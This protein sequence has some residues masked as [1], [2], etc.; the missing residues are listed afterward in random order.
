MSI[1][2]AASSAADAARSTVEQMTLALE[3][4][5][6]RQEVENDKRQL[7]QQELVR[8]Q[9]NGLAEDQKGMKKDINRIL[10]ML[11]DTIKEDLLKLKT[12]V[13]EIEKD[14][15]VFKGSVA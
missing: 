9:I 14:L 13:V 15:K 8:K 12:K 3:G 5:I 6:K 2:E 7:D 10:R 4:R 11:K 1:A